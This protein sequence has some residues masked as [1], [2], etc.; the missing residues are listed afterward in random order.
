[1][2]IKTIIISILIFLISFFWFSNVYSVSFD[3]SPSDVLWEMKNNDIQDTKLDNVW[4][5]WINESLESIKNES[6]SYIDWL[7]FIWLSIALILIMYN[8][9][10]LLANFSDENKFSK[11][12]KR[13]VSIIVG[14]VV[15]TSG[16]LVI[17]VVVSIVQDIF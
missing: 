1:M 3:S 4:W 2:Y 11:I 7:W 12:K 17:K 15:F 10:Y 9:I 5:N 16:Y 8:W 13:F 6:T 14:V